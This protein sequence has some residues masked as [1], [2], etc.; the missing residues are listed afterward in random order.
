NA[1]PVLR[2]AVRCNLYLCDFPSAQSLI[3]RIVDLGFADGKE[4]IAINDMQA[5]LYY[6][7]SEFLL[8]KGDMRGAW[9]SLISLHD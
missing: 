8:K 2:E 9:S 6:R 1:R 5:Q 3:A 4:E 7:E